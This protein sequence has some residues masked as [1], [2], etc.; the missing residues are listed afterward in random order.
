[1]IELYRIREADDAYAKRQDAI[2]ISDKWPLP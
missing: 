2:P 1:M